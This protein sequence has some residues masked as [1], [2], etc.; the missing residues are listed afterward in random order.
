M[1]EYVDLVQAD[2]RYYF[3]DRNRD[4]V[5]PNFA[6]SDEAWHWLDKCEA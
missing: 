2:G 6:T 3:V 4:R 1:M 5:S